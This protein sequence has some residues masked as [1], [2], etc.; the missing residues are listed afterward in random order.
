[1]Q[2]SQ[3]LVLLATQVWAQFLAL[4]TLLLPDPVQVQLELEW[5][6]QVALLPVCVE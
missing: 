6:V 4:Q 3:V 5:P 2:P 1:M